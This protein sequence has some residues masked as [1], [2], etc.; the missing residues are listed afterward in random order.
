MKTI[1]QEQL[2]P[3]QNKTQARSNDYV[4]SMWRPDPEQEDAVK[5]PKQ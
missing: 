2:Y 4:E 5:S 1:D 3:P